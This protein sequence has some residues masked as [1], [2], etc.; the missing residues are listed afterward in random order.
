MKTLIVAMLASL[1]LGNAAAARAAVTR[2]TQ[3]HCVWRG[4]HRVCKRIVRVQRSRCYG[5]AE[6]CR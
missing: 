3:T 5:P 6:R 2:S 1:M 4:H